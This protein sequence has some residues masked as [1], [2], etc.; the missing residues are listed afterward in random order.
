VCRFCKSLLV[1]TDLKVES[2]GQ[3]ALV[4]DDFSPLQ[5]GVTGAFEGHRFRLVGRLRK[6][7]SEGSWNEWCVLF[8]DQRFGWLAEAQGDLV[9]TF[10]QPA[11]A[12]Q[13]VPAAAAAARAEPGT[14]WRIG[15][16]GFNVSDVKQVSVGG[17]EGE[18]SDVFAVGEPV[19]S[20]DLRGSGLAFAT[21]EYRRDAVQA[22]AG[23]FVEFDECRFANLRQLAGWGPP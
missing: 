14:M 18:L 10:L 21:L 20:I 16:S 6:V 23:R 4:P 2:I 15:G 17:A 1:R 8:D 7:W 11:A 22:Y 3:V 19:L 12:A 9:M 5:L 13:G